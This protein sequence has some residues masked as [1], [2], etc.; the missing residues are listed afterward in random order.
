MSDLV[1]NPEDRFSCVA[2]QMIMLGDGW[3]NKG[4]YVQSGNMVV[5]S[6]FFQAVEPQKEKTL[7]PESGY[8]F[9][10]YVTTSS[11]CFQ[12]KPL[13][14]RPFLSQSFSAADHNN[15][16]I[17]DRLVDA[18]CNLPTHSFVLCVVWLFQIRALCVSK[19]NHFHC[20]LLNII[21]L[22]SSVFVT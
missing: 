5:S 13:P 16:S 12:D 10:R 15:S 20:S 9:S 6:Y 3:E 22:T 19:P 21:F 7:K 2:A 14:R 11:Q 8:N 1:G 17:S 4:F 18:P